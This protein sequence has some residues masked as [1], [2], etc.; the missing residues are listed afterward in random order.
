M[1]SINKCIY[2]KYVLPLFCFVTVLAHADGAA[3]MARKL[4]NPLA[5][6]KALMTDNVI[7]FDTGTDGGTAYGF[8][9]QPL[10]AFDMSDK[11]VTILPRGVFPVL[12]LE[13]G[14]DAPVIGSPFFAPQQYQ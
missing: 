8:Q 11:G 10:Y 3:E 6:I 5:N 9:L 1:T 7:G 13:P 2:G 14:M 4:Q 12:G